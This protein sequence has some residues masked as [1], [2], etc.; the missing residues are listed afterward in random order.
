LRVIGREVIF[1]FIQKH[2]NAKPALQ[3]WLCEVESASWSCL[4]E[5]LVSYRA[6]DILTDN[7]VVFHFIS[8]EFKLLASAIC[9]SSIVIVEKIGTI[10]E[11]RK[12]NL[13]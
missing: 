12:W 9:G 13:K 6:A 3:S 1:T 11:Y 4:Q 2:N 7:R 8:G 5:I 10:S